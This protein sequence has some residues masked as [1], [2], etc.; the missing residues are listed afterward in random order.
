M[1]REARIAALDEGLAGGVDGNAL[2]P[3]LCEGVPAFVEPLADYRE[4]RAGVEARESV[5]TAVAVGRTP[6]L[7]ASDWFPAD[8]VTLLG[9]TST[10]WR[11]T[12]RSRND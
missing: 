6:D 8:L 1:W 9:L 10:S 7:G 4:R 2:I 12:R 5:V 3:F 11:M